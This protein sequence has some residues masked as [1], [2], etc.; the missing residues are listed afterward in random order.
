M[1]DE[2]DIY[3]GIYGQRYGTVPQGH[4]ISITEMEFNR[5]VERGLPILV[6]AMHA[7]HP[8]TID[9]WKLRPGA[10]TGTSP[11]PVC[12]G[13]EHVFIS[14]AREDAAMFAQRLSKHF[15]RRNIKAWS[16]NAMKPA[17]WPSLCGR[18]VRCANSSSASMPSTLWPFNVH[19]VLSDCLAAAEKGKRLNNWQCLV[20]DLL[21]A[22]PGNPRRICRSYGAVACFDAHL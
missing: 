20:I 3:I 10:M 22:P 21:P 2:A 7:Q 14:Y 15:A 8:I 1:V 4:D 6:F 18:A 17:S 12:D 5:A 11:G 16:D 9:M 13:K 19:A